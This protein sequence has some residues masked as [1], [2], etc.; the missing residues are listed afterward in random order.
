MTS[1]VMGGGGT[2]KGR[3]EHPSSEEK[4]PRLLPRAKNERKL[5]TQKEKGLPCR[6]GD[7]AYPANE[8]GEKKRG[9]A[10]FSRDCALSPGKHKGGKESSDGGGFAEKKRRAGKKEGGE[11]TRKKKIFGSK[12]QPAKKTLQEA[13]RPEKKKE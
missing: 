1:G 5:I 7:I 8:G 10:T 3:R 11:S 4:E 2:G 12:S 6:W 9:T 13:N